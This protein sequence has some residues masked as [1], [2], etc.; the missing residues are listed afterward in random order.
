M[1]RNFI[2]FISGIFLFSLF[3]LFSYLVHKD[4]FTQI[5][6]NT[7]VRLQDNISRR[8]DDLFSFFSTLGSFEVS[9]VILV[10]TGIVLVYKRKLLTA[11]SAGFLFFIFHLIELYGKF[12]V[13]H[14][15]PAEFMLRTKR[16]IEFPQFHVRS[17]FSY[18]SGHS[19]RTIF[20]SILFITFIWFNV[21][22]SKQVKALLIGGILIFDI[23]MV[24]SRVYLGEHWT[25]D[26]IGGAFL[27]GAFAS[28]VGAVYFQK[29]DSTSLKLRGASKRAGDKGL[30]L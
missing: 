26:V 24:V 21:K 10:I 20:L 13:D 30:K 23:I 16:M 12:F 3:I 5:D 15:P 2:F 7:T 29:W 6:F 14:P 11:F 19:G 18:P 27:G 9:G 4:V 22:L 8:F 17:D 25:S 28:I 1:R